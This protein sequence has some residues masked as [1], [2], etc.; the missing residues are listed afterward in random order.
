MGYT[1]PFCFF[2]L[3]FIWAKSSVGQARGGI[4]D[5]LWLGRFWCIVRW[6]FFGGSAARL[7]GGRWGV[8]LNRRILRPLIF[9]IALFGDRAA[10]REGTAF[11]Q[12]GFLR[13]TGDRSSW[14]SWEGGS[15]LTVWLRGRGFPGQ[16]ILCLGLKNC[17]IDL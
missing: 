14:V 15:I 3:W 12:G 10:C 8:L 17:Q 11:L 7:W 6:Q 4:D 9:G 16:I 1:L 2:Q 13:F 5:A